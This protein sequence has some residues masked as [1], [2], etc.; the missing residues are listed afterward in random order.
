MIKQLQ[1]IHSD[2]F[3]DENERNVYKKAIHAKVLNEVKALVVQA[4]RFRYEI[5]NNNAVKKKKKKK[6]KKKIQ[7]KKKDLANALRHNTRNDS[8]ILFSK[9]I[10]IAM[11]E[12]CKDPA[13]IKSHQLLE[14]TESEESVK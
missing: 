6:K 4:D 13:I 7:Q 3:K 8:E 11:K 14:G 2:G 10:G 5:S 12:L 9:R 1:I